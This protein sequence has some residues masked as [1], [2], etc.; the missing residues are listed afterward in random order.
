MRHSTD[1]SPLISEGRW[2]GQLLH[3]PR[4]DGGFGYDP[5]FFDPQ[6]NL[7]GAEMTLEQ[8]NSVSHR[9]HALRT[10]MAMIRENF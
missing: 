9:G 1:P 3:E 5:I 4:G 7:T 2:H 8:K 6:M 10:M